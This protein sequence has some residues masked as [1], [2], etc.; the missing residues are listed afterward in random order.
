MNLRKHKD[1]KR[2]SSKKKLSIPVCG[3][4]ALTQVHQGVQVS[5][6]IFKLKHNTGPRQQV[7]RSRKG[8]F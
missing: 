8:D 1:N 5:E 6:S 7:I 4:S 2:G 3:V